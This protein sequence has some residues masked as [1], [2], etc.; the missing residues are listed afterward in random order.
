MSKVEE[1]NC[2]IKENLQK[3][4]YYELLSRSNKNIVANMLK[5]RNGKLIKK[6]KILKGD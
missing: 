1:I 5:I 3:I 4:E 2:R 6:M